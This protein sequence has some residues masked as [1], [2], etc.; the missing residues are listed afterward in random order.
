AGETL[1]GLTTSSAGRWYYTANWYDDDLGRLTHTANYGCAASPPTPATSNP[2]EPSDTV[3]VTEFGY[4]NLGRRDTVT[5]NRGITTKTIYDDAGRV[6]YV[7]ENFD[8]FDPDYESTTI[9]GDNDETDID[10]VTKYVYNDLGLLCQQIALHPSGNQTTRY[11]YSLELTVKGCPVP[12]NGLLRGIIYPDSTCTVSGTFSNA[13]HV[14]YTY[15]ADGRAQTKTDQREV[16]ITYTYDESGRL[17]L[18][19]ANTVTGVD[20]T[21]LSIERGYDN[22]GRL[23]TVTSWD[24]A[25][26]ASGTTVN[27]VKF[28]YNEWGKLAKETLD[29]TGTAETASDH[30]VVYTYDNTKGARLTSIDY[31]EHDNLE[32]TLKVYYD[33]GTS[34][35]INDRLSRIETI[36][37]AASGDNTTFAQYAYLGADTIVG[38]TYPDRT[39]SPGHA[40]PG[41]D[42]GL[43][44]TYDIASGDSDPYDGLDVF[45]RVTHMRWVDDAGTG[46]SD[47]HKYVYDRGSN[48]L[49]REQ[50]DGGIVQ[51]FGY[52]GLD[53]LAKFGG[54]SADGSVC[55]IVDELESGFVTITGT[56]T[57]QTSANGYEGH[58]FENTNPD[59]ENAQSVKFTPIIPTDG[60][61]DVY[62]YLPAGVSGVSGVDVD[63]YD[64]TTLDTSAS[65]D[66]STGAGE[67]HRIGTGAYTLSAG[68]DAY[69]EIIK[70]ASST[71]TIYAD[72]VRFVLTNGTSEAV[73][74]TTAT[75]DQDA[76]SVARNDD[77]DYVV[78]WVD[79]RGDDP[80]IRFRRYN[81]DG[82]AKDTNDQLVFSASGETQSQPDVAIEDDDEFVV[83]WLRD[84]D[85]VAMRFQ[86]SGT[87]KDGS[88]ISVATSVGTGGHPAIAAEADTGDFVVTWVDASG[89]NKEVKYQCYAADATPGTAGT[90]PGAGYTAGDQVAPDVGRADSGVF[91]IVWTD[92]YPTDDRICAQAFTDAGA[93]SGSTFV[94]ASESSVTMANPAIGM[95]DGGT[96]VIAWDADD[97]TDTD[98]RARRYASNHA[99]ADSAFDVCDYAGN[100]DSPSVGAVDNEKFVVAW[101]S[102]AQDPDGDGVFARFYSDAEP[103]GGEYRVN[104]TTTS[105]Q[106]ASSVSMDPGG[107]VAVV[108][109]S[110]GQDA[111]STWGV[112]GRVLSDN[113]WYGN[114]LWDLDA[115]GNWET[116]TDDDNDQTRTH[117]AAN[118]IATITATPG[119]GAPVY[120]AAGNM[121]QASFSGGYL[122]LTYD[123]WN[124]LAK[125]GTGP[126]ATMYEY[127]GLGPPCAAVSQPDVAVRGR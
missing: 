45:G 94:V 109:A 25:A 54:W 60:D 11:V 42:D 47:Q 93:T 34:G 91:V 37:N 13:D 22:F 10:R 2:P 17:T 4:D 123:A 99:A 31:D 41:V 57:D 85:V 92:E 52:D 118:E 44:M 32:A 53:R 119:W 14:E 35:E 126:M 61:Y 12:S 75:D 24:N 29:P 89:A 66:Q 74:N 64:G 1:G 8:D 65:M 76:P 49:L 88:P 28:S 3:I 46:V 106:N 72:A 78:V 84:D 113:E 69:V 9:G 51:T 101:T 96:Y 116:F 30:T 114:Q 5:N 33:Y 40:D 68:T 59:S 107:D 73:V 108:W 36:R 83:T 124:R 7:A 63:V 39:G 27:E 67:W 77:G 56:W 103:E 6:T 82:T 111:A 90:A 87:A 122:L 55:M 112:Y 20:S 16:V 48:R 115:V 100:E 71:S 15:F 50:P 86:A 104:T 105:D 121:T 23:V 120:D 19:S 38:V 127:D 18:E 97:A 26:P 117:N 110:Y 70:P 58:Y 98:I 125:N 80:A 21:I 62:V 95:G 79:D 43:N 81:A 102:D